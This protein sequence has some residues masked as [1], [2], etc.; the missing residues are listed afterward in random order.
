MRGRGTGACVHCQRNYHTIQQPHFQ[1]YT[2]KTEPQDI[3]VPEFIA[4]LLTTANRWKQAKCVQN[5]MW[6]IQTMKCHSALKRKKTLIPAAPW[7]N[8]ED[9]MLSEVTVRFHLREA[10]WIGKHT[11]IE[12][13]KVGPAAGGHC[14][15]RTEPQFGKM[16]SSKGLFHNNGN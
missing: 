1:I 5:K 4:V 8:L 13:R 12:S 16:E 7:M 9:V 6:S 11:E 3:C 10:P 2:L 14:S 15:V